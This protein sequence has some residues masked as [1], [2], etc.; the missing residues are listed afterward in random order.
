MSERVL[1]Y[2][3]ETVT[4]RELFAMAMAMMARIERLELL[5]GNLANVVLCTLSDEDPPRDKFEAACEVLE[6]FLKDL[7]EEVEAH[8]RIRARL[9]FLHTPE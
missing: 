6:D 9:D 3:E 8:Q 4:S 1:E 7:K 2:S 5:V